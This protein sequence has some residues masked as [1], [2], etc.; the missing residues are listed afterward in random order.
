MNPAEISQA[1]ARLLATKADLVVGHRIVNAAKQPKL[2]RLASLVFRFVAQRLVPTSA[3]DT[4][5][6]LKLF[7]GP[8]AKDLFDALST[9][10]FAFDVELLRR[11]DQA[12]L[13]IEDVPVAWQHQPGSQ[14]NT[15]TDS[16]RMIRE[17]LAVRRML[18]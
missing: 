9:T 1:L 14:V 18:D 6:A 4:Q 8:V 13:R 12:G 16:V 7:R 15:I 11:A 17:I 10:G 5:C 3:T 2:R